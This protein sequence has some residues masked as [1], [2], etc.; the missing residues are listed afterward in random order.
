MLGQKKRKMI[1]GSS[2]RRKSLRP[3][4]K[5]RKKAESLFHKWVV[6]R[7]KNRCFTC[8]GYGDQAGHYRHGKLDFDPDNLH[9]QC[10]R[11]NKWLHGNL[12]TY[13]LNLISLHS[14]KWVEKLV[15]RSNTESNKFTRSQ[16][17]ELIKR[18]S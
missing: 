4:P 11:C 12:G 2:I 18:Y 8:G 15:Q 17:E 14:K 7:D 5:L 3:L 6:K 9:C 13:T 10:A 16:L 1:R